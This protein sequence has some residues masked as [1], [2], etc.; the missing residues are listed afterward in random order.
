ME[1]AV[2]LSR[3]IISETSPRQI[4]FL[5]EVGGPRSFP[6]EIGIHEALAIDRRLKGIETSRPLTHELLASVIGAMGGRL[7][8]IVVS[9]LREHTFYATLYIERDGEVIEVDSR[10]SDAIALGVAYETPMF[11]AEHVLDQVVAGPADLESQ[12][13]GLRMRREELAE[14]IARAR[15]RL[16]KADE[17]DDGQSQEARRLQQYLIEMQAELEAIE[18]ILRHIE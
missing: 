18:E 5:S 4:I 1:V 9:D 12:R 15:R 10:P 13:E 3:I 16:S 7:A 11:V 6:I 17:L 2:Q 14:E 8:R